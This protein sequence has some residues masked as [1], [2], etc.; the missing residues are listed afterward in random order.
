MRDQPPAGVGMLEHGI[1]AACRYYFESQ[2]ILQ[3]SASFVSVNGIHS[4]GPQRRRFNIILL[5]SA[6]SAENFSICR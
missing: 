1:I 5:L 2:K 6:L 4:G 3:K